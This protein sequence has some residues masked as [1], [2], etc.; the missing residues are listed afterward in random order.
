MIQ[1]N[2]ARLLHAMRKHGISR[3]GE[4]GHT[5]QHKILARGKFQGFKV[6][7]LQNDG[8]PQR[9]SSGL[10]VKAFIETLKLLKL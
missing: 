7:T 2:M 5:S 9:P 6:S 3:R 4:E 8:P 1:G 10:K